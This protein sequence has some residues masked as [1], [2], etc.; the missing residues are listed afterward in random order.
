M[1]K[2][3]S[4]SGE[5]QKAAP[6]S[7]EER[8]SV[9]GHLLETT[10]QVTSTAM[11]PE[12][13]VG[14]VKGVNILIPLAKVSFLGGDNEKLLSQTMYVDNVAYLVND[15]SFELIQMFSYFSEFCKGSYKLR[16]S[17]MKLTADWLE[18][19]KENIDAALDLIATVDVAE[20][21]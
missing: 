5:S 16:E 13:T 11:A 8:V 12:F 21:T 3:K 14:T 19:A 4:V 1:A 20:G 10:W 15:L 6:K 17:R 7:T 18:K 2:V 9:H